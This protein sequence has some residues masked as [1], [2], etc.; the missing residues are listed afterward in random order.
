M[1]G[2]RLSA[3]RLRKNIK[4]MK[5]YLVVNLDLCRAIKKYMHPDD[6]IES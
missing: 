6:V 3:P 5:F 4:W 2:I 1:T